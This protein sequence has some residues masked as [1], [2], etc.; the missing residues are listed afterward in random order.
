MTRFTELEPIHSNTIM[1][2]IS[3]E[4]E[5][6]KKRATST[7]TALPTDFDESALPQPKEIVLPA[8][9]AAPP[10]SA[11]KSGKLTKSVAGGKLVKKNRWSV[12]SSKTAVA[13]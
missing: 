10:P 12:R 8:T 6:E 2:T 13:V 3:K 9:P 4:E 11:S 1:T 7:V 5:K